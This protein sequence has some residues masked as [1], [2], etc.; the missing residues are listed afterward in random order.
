MFLRLSRLVLPYVAF[1]AHLRFARHRPKGAGLPDAIWWTGGPKEV[2]A[3]DGQ[4]VD[5]PPRDYSV[6]A[7]PWTA[8]IGCVWD[9]VRAL[10]W[11]SSDLEAIGVPY[12]WMGAAWSPLIACG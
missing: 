5:L 3:R 4:G 11:H 2:K 8:A 1:A 10:R 9:R 12:A 7:G 6:Q